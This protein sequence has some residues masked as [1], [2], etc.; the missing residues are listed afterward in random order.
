M[1][2][3]I[4]FLAIPLLLASQNS[5]ANCYEQASQRYSLDVGLL[6]AIVKVESN[7]N[8]YAIHFDSDGSHDIG[9][10]QINT[11]HLPELAKYGITEQKLLDN[12]CLN[13]NIG[14]WILSTYIHKHGQTWRAV[15]IYN[16]GN[17]KNL[18]QARI[19]YVRKVKAAYDKVNR[20]QLEYAY[21]P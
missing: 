12:A 1:R 11:S 17:K 15:G 6:R 5:L 13:L 3:F 10:T 7:F 4:I 19:T 9:L 21:T 2:S 8:Q 20:Q 14:A 18:E 16:T